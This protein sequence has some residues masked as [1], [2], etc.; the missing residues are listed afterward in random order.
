MRYFARHVRR[1]QPACRLRRKHHRYRVGAGARGVE[2]ELD[3]RN[4]W[5]PANLAQGSLLDSFPRTIEAWRAAFQNADLDD[6]AAELAESEAFR[7]WSPA[8]AG[9]ALGP[10]IEDV[11]RIFCEQSA[12]PEVATLARSECAAA[13]VRALVVNPRPS[14]AIPSFLRVAPR[15]HYSVIHQDGSDFLVAALD[16]RLVSGPLTPL[17]GAILRADDPTATAARLDVA[18]TGSRPSTNELRAIGLIA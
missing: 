16:G 7:P 2:P 10:P 17:L 6:L 15:G 4:G 9:D 12:G 8:D 1:R 14:F 11:F 18:E 3:A 5:P 13:I